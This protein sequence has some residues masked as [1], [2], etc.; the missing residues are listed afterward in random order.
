MR[1]LVLGG[2]VF[3]GRALTEAATLR[4]HEVTTFTRSTLPP[5]VSDG[6]VEAVFGDRTDPSAF[7]FASGRRWDAVLDTWWGAPRIVQH[8]VEN[9][10]RHA[11][12]YSYVSSGAVYQAE[13]LPLGINED[14]QTVE[15]DP[16]AELGDYSVNKRGAELAILEGFGPDASLLARPGLILGP[17]EWPAR[18]PWWLN[19][20]AQGGEVMAPGPSDLS[21]QYI[22]VRDL[23]EWMVQ[24]AENSIAGAFNAISPG[25]HAN[26]SEMLEGCKVTTNSNAHFTWVPPDFVLAH[27][28]QPVFDMPLWITPAMH[29]LYGFDTSRAA[30]EGLSCRPMIETIAATW[31]IMQSGNQS[32]LP[33]GVK[34][35]GISTEKEKEVLAAWAD[36]DH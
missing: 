4:G 35:P 7:D 17:Y 1:I 33:V 9:L 32:F 5:G 19:R 21:L 11:P 20:I 13:P 34:A 27:G 29:G 25:G 23:A 10:R 28:I 14:F 8:S 6:L 12:Y 30:L 26:M 31:A 24:C 16:S 15:A 22:D 18:L 3:V 36:R 2:G